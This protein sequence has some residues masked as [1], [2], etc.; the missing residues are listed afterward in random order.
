LVGQLQVAG[1]SSFAW[2]RT[3][4]LISLTLTGR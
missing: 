3:Q 2:K 1:S 4:E